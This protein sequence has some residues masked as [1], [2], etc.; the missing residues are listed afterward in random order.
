VPFSSSNDHHSTLHTNHYSLTNS[1]HHHTTITS[2][3]TLLITQVPIRFPPK[4][5][6]Q[7]S[8]DLSRVQIIEFFEKVLLIDGTISR[9]YY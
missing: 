3:Y 2:P 4:D 6:L 1:L 8:G 9:L 7:T 5:T